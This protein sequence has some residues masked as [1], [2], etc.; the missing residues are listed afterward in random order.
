MVETTQ[1][2]IVTP[3]APAPPVAPAEPQALAPDE[4]DF[5]QVSAMRGLFEIARLMNE[6]LENV[7]ESKRGTFTKALQLTTEVIDTLDTAIR[8]GRGLP[9][10]AAP[11]A[12]GVPKSDSSVSSSGEPRAIPPVAGGAAQADNGAK[13]TDITREEMTVRLELAEAKADARISRFEERID[14]AID[15][16]RR[17]T[18]RVEAAIGNLKSTTI[19][20]AISAVLAIVLGIAAFNATV[21][22]NMV[23]SFESG[24]NTAAAISESTKRLEVLQDRI[25][26]QQKQVP[27]A[28]K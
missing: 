8:E 22:S 5:L 1:Q 21:L 19:V 12:G 25:E 23:A 6:S 28:T 10:K 27:P 11:A 4:R 7:P 24:K 13:M 3:S 15:A 26:A 17:D 2:P 9:P 16:L 18:D 14:S 20:T